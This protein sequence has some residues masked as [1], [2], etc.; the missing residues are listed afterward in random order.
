LFS[1]NSILKNSLGAAQGDFDYF[2]RPL[3]CAPARAGVVETGHAPPVAH[4]SVGISERDPESFRFAF[5]FGN[6]VL[7]IILLV[8]SSAALLSRR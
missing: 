7:G 4:S 5:H 3:L 8:V 6:V 1:L 2:T